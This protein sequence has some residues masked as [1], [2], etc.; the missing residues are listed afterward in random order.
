M[1]FAVNTKNINNAKAKI[2]DK[3]I[4]IVYNVSR[5]CPYIRLL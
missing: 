1:L 4:K 3:T 2:S 5:M